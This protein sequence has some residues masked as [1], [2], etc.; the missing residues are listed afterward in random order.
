MNSLKT[1]LL[2]VVVAVCGA[3]LAPAAAHA[4]P[5]PV[6]IGFEAGLPL[7]AGFEAS[8]RVRDSWR[9]G[10]QF[11][12]VSGLTVLGAEARWLMRG[13]AGGLVPSL[14]AGA[15]QYFLKDG[16]RSATPVGVHAALGLDY[17]LRGAP[18]SLGAEIGAMTTFGSSNDEHV[19]VFSIRNNVTK[20]TFNIAARYHF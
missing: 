9:L 13:E 3:P 15:D 10:A 20:A 18:V 5:G 17:F 6:S 1:I 2:A 7:V 12:R 4:A 11:G 14:I 16:G 8:Y 19:E